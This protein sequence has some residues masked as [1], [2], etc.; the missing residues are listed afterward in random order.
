MRTK[1][2]G[3]LETVIGDFLEESAGNENLW[4]DV[5]FATEGLVLQMA[6]AAACVFDAAV[7]ASDY[8]EN[9]TQARADAE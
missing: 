4:P 6:A 9:E 1:L 7:E 2:Q 3:E 5:Y 8:A